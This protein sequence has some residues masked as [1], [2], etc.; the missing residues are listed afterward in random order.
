MRRHPATA[1]WRRAWNVRLRWWWE[2]PVPLDLWSN[3]WEA[4]VEVLMLTIST[5]PLDSIDLLRLGGERE[6]R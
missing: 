5:T 3:R 1:A 6:E 4:I 2:A